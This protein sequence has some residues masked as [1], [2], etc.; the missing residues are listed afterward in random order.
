MIATS[1]GFVAGVDAE[2]AVAVERDRPEVALVEAVD[3]DR[4]EARGAQLVDRV[5]ELH[6]EELRRGLEPLEVVGE[7]ED[8]RAALG[9]VAA[10]ALEDAGAVV[11][12]VRADVDPGIR[13]VH[14]L[15]V[16]PD[17]LGLLHVGPFPCLEC[18]VVRRRRPAARARATRTSSAREARPCACR[19]RRR[20][21][22]GRR[23]AGVLSIRTRS[24][25][26]ERRRARP[27]PGAKP[28]AASTASGPATRARSAPVSARRPSARRRGGRPG[29]ARAPDAPVAV[30]DERLDDLPQLA[31]DRR[32]RR[33]RRSACRSGTPRSAPPRPP[34]GARRSPARRARAR[35]PD[36]GA[37]IG[38]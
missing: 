24:T 6:V 10:D 34:R 30:E 37:S 7:P 12:A 11:Q 17:L 28:V 20:P 14:E 33:P 15:A 25:L 26:P 3:R 19:C 8:R 35:P 36:L 29:R 22:A 32:A 38:T 21:R 5:R 2:L 13:P 4:L 18:Y 16:H 31:A 1:T 23:R 9:G 27:R